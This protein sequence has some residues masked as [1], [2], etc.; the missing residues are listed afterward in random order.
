MVLLPLII[1]MCL[2]TIYTYIYI[3]YT[4]ASRLRGRIPPR[5]YNPSLIF[6]ERKLLFQRC[7]YGEK[8]PTVYYDEFGRSV[9]MRTPYYDNR[10]S[11]RATLITQISGTHLYIYHFVPEEEKKKARPAAKQHS[12]FL[13][14]YSYLYYNSTTEMT[15]CGMDACTRTSS[16]YLGP[17]MH[18]IPSK[19]LDSC[20]GFLHAPAM[21]ILQTGCVRVLV[22]VC[23]CVWVHPPLL[24]IY[25]TACNCARTQTLQKR[26]ASE[27]KRIAILVYNNNIFYAV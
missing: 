5:Q 11:S 15:H 13:F 27:G 16:V 3:L 17:L 2:Y 10:P 21:A 24:I 9:H 1:S 14:I 26:N 18:G 25:W 8:M 12:H 22:C 4:H 6:A 7:M 19:A 23:V 20:E